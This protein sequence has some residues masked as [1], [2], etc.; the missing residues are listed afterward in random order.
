MPTFMVMVLVSTCALKLLLIEMVVEL[1]QF[2]FSVYSLHSAH[3][4]I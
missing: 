3:V 2:Q 1:F 4:H